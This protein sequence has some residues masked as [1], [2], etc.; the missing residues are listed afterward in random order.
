LGF[1]ALAILA[2]GGNDSVLAHFDA[3]D[4]AQ[5]L[6]PTEKAEHS[7]LFSS[8]PPRVVHNLYT[9]PYAMQNHEHGISFQAFSKVQELQDFFNVLT[10][11][12][13]REDKVYVS[14]IEARDYPISGTQWHPEKNAFEWTPDQHIPHSPEAIEITQEVANFI[15][16]ASRYNSHAPRS[17]KEEEELIIYNFNEGLRYTGKQTFEGEEVSFDEVY[18][19]PDAKTFLRSSR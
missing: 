3:E 9:K 5:P 8:L 16:G 18:V 6:Y 11:S 15:V 4:F 13:D 1:E 7:R 14:T 10:L 2:A 12:I 19:F 17:R